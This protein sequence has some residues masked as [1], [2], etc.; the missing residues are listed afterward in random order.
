MHRFEKDRQEYLVGV[1][2]SSVVNYGFRQVR[3][4]ARPADFMS[5]PPAEPTMSDEQLAEKIAS[6]LAAIAVPVG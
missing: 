4:P 3:K 6:T 5:H 2:A 1:I